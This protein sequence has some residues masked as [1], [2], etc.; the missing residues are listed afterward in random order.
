MAGGGGVRDRTVVKLD[1]TSCHFSDLILNSCLAELLR[2][3]KDLLYI[4]KYSVYL[5][6]QKNPILK[7]RR[8]PKLVV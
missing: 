3:R 4:S 8:V 6:H 2:K 7:L 5:W 1:F